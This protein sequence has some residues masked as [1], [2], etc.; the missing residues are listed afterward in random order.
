[1]GGDDAPKIVIEGV[2]LVLKRFPTVHFLL[3]GD[4]EGLEEILVGFPDVAKVSTVCHADKVIAPDEKPSVAIRKGRDSSMWHA[5]ESVKK[6]EAAGVI[7]AGNTGAL[8]AMSK[9]CLRMIEGV[10]RPAI[11][12][13]LPTETKC[14]TLML[15]LGANSE[16]KAKHLADFA[17][18][19]AICYKSVKGNGNPKVGLLNI[20]SEDTKGREEIR[21]AASIIEKSDYPLDYIGFV[22]G[23][24]IGKGVANVVVADGFTGNVALKTIEGSVKLFKHCLKSAVASSFLAKI[25]FLFARK[26]LKKLG[27]EMDPRLYNGAVLLGL[28][29][30]SV[31][32]HGGTDAVGF[33]NAI[34]YAVDLIKNDFANKIAKEMKE[35]AENGNGNGKS[36]SNGKSKG[37]GVAKP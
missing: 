29:G 17:L 19:G 37:K 23:D 7:S 35:V 15:D 12:S 20:G 13:F 16:C 8:M 27:Q 21:E 18:M 25:G 6:G 30:I 33:A 14:P 1:M 32:S 36:K 2:R 10:E 31:K 5:I 22:E 9:V 26:A 34:G 4:K 28:N 11:A 24:D 3:H